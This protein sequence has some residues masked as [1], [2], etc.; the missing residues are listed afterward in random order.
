MVMLAAGRPGSPC[1]PF[2]ERHSFR[3]FTGLFCLPDL[4]V[5]GL[6]SERGTMT[7]TSTW[8]VVGL[9]SFVPMLA[10]AQD[11]ATSIVGVWKQT[12]LTRKDVATGNVSPF[13][14]EQQAGYR[15][16]TRGGH[17]FIFNVYYPR[18][19]PGAEPTDAERAELF[20]TSS[21]YTGTYRIDGDKVVVKIDGSWVESWTGTDRSFAL[22]INGNRM[23]MTTA[24]FKN[25]VDGREVVLVSTLERA[26]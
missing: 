12:S 4:A 24:P 7:R 9:F 13:L 25:V 19:R 23:T 14:G 8:V 1:D 10:L 22:A 16:F 15:I 5:A 17:A 11:L 20:K 2:N 26:E 21:A 6:D 3:L 18:K